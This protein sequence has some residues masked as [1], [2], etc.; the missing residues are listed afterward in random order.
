[1]KQPMSALLIAPDHMMR[2]SVV[3]GRKTITIREDHRDY[4]PGP[5]MLCCHLVPWAVMADITDVRHCTL[6][7]V[8]HEEYEDDGFHSQDDLLQGMQRFYPNMTPDSPVTV[9]R[10][11]KTRGFLVDYSTEYRLQPEK[12]YSKIKHKD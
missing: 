8:T 6:R 5:V 11:E 9:I 12:L 2:T 1:M 4:R 10:W 3:Y 7:E